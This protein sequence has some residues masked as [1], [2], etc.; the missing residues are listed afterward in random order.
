MVIG[1]AWQKKKERLKWDKKTGAKKGLTIFPK[2]W[3]A[4]HCEGIIKSIYI[5]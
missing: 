3:A 5:I 1:K 2:P 4:E